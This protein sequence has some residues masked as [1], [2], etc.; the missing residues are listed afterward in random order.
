[1]K[2]VVVVPVY[3]ERK[4]VV[5]VLDKIATQPDVSQIVIIDDGST[6]G[7]GDILRDWVKSS[8][9][10]STLIEHKKNNGNSQALT[11]G[12]NHVIGLLEKSLL[13][14]DD[15][16][17]TIDSDGQHDPGQLQ[18]FFQ[19][20]KP[21]KLDVLWARRDFSKY[22]LFKRLG[23]RLMSLIGSAFAGMKF[24]DI[25][26]GYHL[27]KIGALQAAMSVRA[28]DWRYSIGATLAVTLARLS[29]RVTNEPVANI[30]LYRS[31]TRLLDVF[32]NAFA[33]A[34]AFYNTERYLITTS[35]RLRERFVVGVL[36]F[37]SF[38]SIVTMVATKSIYLG[39]DS[40]NNYAH[41]WYISKYIFKGA[42][43]M[44]VSSL[45]GGGALT[46][47]YGFIP[48]TLAALMRPVIGDFA[49]TW[50]M[51]IGVLLLIWVVRHVWLHR[52]PWLLA[53]FVV[54]PFLIEAL[55]SFQMAF[56][57]GLLFGFL[58]VDSLSKKRVWRSLL[59]FVLSVG[60]HLFVMGPLLFLYTVWIFFRKP[61]L[62]KN[63]VVVGAFGTVALLPELWYVAGTPEVSDNSLIALLTAV[64]GS[65]ITRGLLFLWPFALDWLR[66]FRGGALLQPRFGIAMVFI[67]G[68]YLF[69]INGGD[70]KLNGYEGLYTTAVNPYE[71]YTQTQ[72]F[73]P[74]ATYR[75]MEAN[76][77]EQGE[78]FL[79]QHGAVLSS[80]FF[81]ESMGR[82]IWSEGGYKRLIM[83]K[84]IDF[85]I[86]NSSYKEY[87]KVFY[88]SE[89]GILN[90]LVEQGLAHKTY[91]DPHSKFVVF[92]LR[93]FR[94]ITIRNL[95][96]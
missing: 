27:F 21:E 34:Q 82:K 15:V 63:I 10:Q 28:R 84:H 59:W 3:N 78:Y 60:T 61:Y 23:N 94:E 25:E 75:V 74:G 18:E 13:D 92:D 4:T 42:L 67:T 46:F 7:S 54:S 5:S 22:P 14:A 85:V 64:A 20:F 71:R 26:C 55:L 9:L 24:H 33:M 47:P 69:P 2:L 51:I 6:D 72:Y 90:S 37:L 11:T 86:I 68:M 35:E 53:L 19:N 62:R 96:S 41:V 45:D 93:P 65:L 87:S 57:W 81:S 17:A 30:K 12:F 39:A 56:V 52:S 79:I 31:R 38:L 58:Y 88:N 32:I 29:F 40:I 83:R 16:V 36:V 77:E 91:E 50:T 8:T 76:N 49:V 44:H 66:S 70:L 73:V 80:E 43:P 89:M 95:S 1:M 48:W